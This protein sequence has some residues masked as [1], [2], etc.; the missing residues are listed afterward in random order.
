MRRSQIALKSAAPDSLSGIFNGRGRLVE[1]GIPCLPVRL[2]GNLYRL[3]PS[4]RRALTE[5]IHKK[6]AL[7]ESLPLAIQ[8]VPPRAVRLRDSSRSRLSKPLRIAQS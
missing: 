8:I 4:P 6:K 1:M 2:C 3:A 5:L 7:E